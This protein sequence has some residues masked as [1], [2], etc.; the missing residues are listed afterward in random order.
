[1]ERGLTA[2]GEKS[3]LPGKPMTY[4]STR[5]FLEIFGLRNIREL[6]SLREIDELLPEGIGEVEEEKETLSQL[7]DRMS[8]ELTSTYSEGE[9]ELAKINEQLQAVDTTSEFFEQEK[10]RERDRRDRD[11]AKEIRERL[12]LGDHVDEKDRR[13][14]DRYEAKLNAPPEE[15][16][17]M[18]TE[19]L[20]AE[21]EDR[22][23][24]SSELESLTE[25]SVARGA[26]ASS[27]V[28]HEENH[29]ETS[30]EDELFD[31]LAVNADWDDD[32]AAEI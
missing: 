24:I 11:R 3:D 20:E 15:V 28:A 26:H 14:L 18:Q 13:W 27:D 23:Q 12:V 21:A 5:K 8:T 4:V 10:Q 7:T 25:E 16:A 9:E 31:E 30:G 2:F 22:P 1:M 32:D 6:P 19:A 29:E 17:K